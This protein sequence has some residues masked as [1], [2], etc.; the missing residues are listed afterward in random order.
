MP[1]GFFDCTSPIYFAT[2]IMLR[3]ARLELRAF[4]DDGKDMDFMMDLSNDLKVQQ[5]TWK[6]FVVPRGPKFKD[7]VTGWV[8]RT[9]RIVMTS[10][11]DT[12][13][14]IPG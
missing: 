1:V 8:T 14:S 3:T 9:F 13:N 4:K 11:C 12:K 5:M 2:N 10:L 7:T 6:E